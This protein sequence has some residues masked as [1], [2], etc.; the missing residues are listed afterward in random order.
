MFHF[1]STNNKHNLARPRL[2]ALRWLIVF[3]I[4]SILIFSSWFGLVLTTVNFEGCIYKKVHHTV[5]SIRQNFIQ[6][7][8]RRRDGAFI[9]RVK[10]HFV[11][12][13][14]T[15]VDPPRPRKTQ[16]QLARFL[17]SPV[18][19]LFFWGNLKVVRDHS[20]RKTKLAGSWARDTRIAFCA[21]SKSQRT[22]CGHGD[23]FS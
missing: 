22:I 18:S 16:E 4:V 23:T 7:Q 10:F 6:T 9:C 20:E 15:I 13:S 21:W 12:T 2:S 11:L 3:I 5:K 8:L 19:A 14:K 1:H 17:S